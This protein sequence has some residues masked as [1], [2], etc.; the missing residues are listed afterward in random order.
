MITGASVEITRRLAAGGLT[1]A[2]AY[3][4]PKRLFAQVDD[5]TEHAFKEAATA[6]VRYTHWHFDH[7]GSNVWLHEAGAGILAHE[8]TRNWLAECTFL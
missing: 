1:F 3:L 8:N 5:P 4:A 6:K 2:A 7:T